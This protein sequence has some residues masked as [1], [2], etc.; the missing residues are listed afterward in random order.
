[1]TNPLIKLL[2]DQMPVL[3]S[4]LLFSIFVNML[5]LTGPLFMLQVYD[6]VLNSRSEAT[7][8]ALVIVMAGLFIAFGLLEC[9]RR[10]LACRIGAELQSRLDP[11]VFLA[12]QNTPASTI[13]Q[14]KT[15]LADVEAVQRFWTSSVVLAAF[16]LPWTPVFIVVIFVFHPLLGWLAVAGGAALVLIS[17]TN[18]MLCWRSQQ[19]AQRAVAQSDRFANTVRLQS[20]TVNG[21]G[22]GQTM[23]DRW[24]KSRQ[25]SLTSLV[26]H[27]D[28]SNSFVALAKSLRFFLQSAMLGLGALLVLRGEIGAGAMIAAMIV[29]GRV[30][31]PIEQLIG[32]WPVVARARTARKSLNKLLQV[33]HNPDPSM[34]LARP[35]AT[36]D[37]EAVT[38]VSPDDGVIRLHQISFRLSPG[39]ALGIIGETA[40]GK[41]TLARVLA[42]LWQPVSG[43]VRLGGACLEQYGGN[44]L[45][46]FVGYLPQNV[47]L[48]D[49]T[50]GE[51]I[52]RMR[53]NPKAD[54]VVMAARK[55]GA[56]DMIMQLKNGYDTRVSETDSRLSGGQKQQLG[57]A[58]AL[59]GTPVLLIL[60]EPTAH[61]D[62]TAIAGFNTAV[63]D[64]KSAGGA[65]IIMTHR[66]ASVVECSQLLF[67]ENGRVRSLGPHE[68]VVG[69]LLRNV[70]NSMPKTN[71]VNVA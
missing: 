44:S 70:G 60:D 23:A 25:A 53:E 59:F 38:V 2:H 45:A 24:L 28:R 66:P 6:R 36:L 55:A 3:L 48:F 17:L 31:A 42:G 30:L 18:Q 63:R 20:E 15:G 62:A 33:A 46:I 41:T 21:L 56:H 27:T 29:L 49:G 61:L 7:L 34:P 64:M 32:G 35:K 12:V 40:A 26:A 65:V 58:R 1:M 47:T 52:A 22:M 19:S 69:K 51:N 50:I 5:M 16:D 8:V 14:A 54:A 9:A 10:N 43:K 39:Q 71:S 11:V 67:L 68:E 4:V 13:T 57:L 37:L